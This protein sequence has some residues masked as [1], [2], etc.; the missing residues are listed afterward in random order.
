MKGMDAHHHPVTATG[1]T[2]TDQWNDMIQ[3]M[4]DHGDPS[5]KTMT[6]DEARQ[7][8]LTTVE[9]LPIYGS[10]LYKITQNPQTAYAEDAVLGVNNIGIQLYK[11][12][13][14]IPYYTYEL[15]NLLR[16]GYVP[17]TLFYISVSEGDGMHVP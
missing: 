16:W 9:S 7:A 4:F 11:P 17:G 8:Y 6:E 14:A 2:N 12:D 5:I 1:M 10:T 3:D 13:S 15:K